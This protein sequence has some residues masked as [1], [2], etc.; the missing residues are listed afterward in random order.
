MP[1]KALARLLAPLTPT[2]GART[3]WGILG[4]FLAVKSSSTLVE[5]LR[6]QPLDYLRLP[7]ETRLR[8]FPLAKEAW[9]GPG[10]F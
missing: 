7:G 3:F 8:D 9:K 5:K 6:K 1:R 2:L 10:P 4:D